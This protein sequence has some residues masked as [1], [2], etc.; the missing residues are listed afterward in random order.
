MRQGI[1]NSL[2]MNVDMKRSRSGKGTITL[3]FTNDE[4]LERIVE[5]L[6]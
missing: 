2:K 1:H 4:Q 6:K 5:A 3:H